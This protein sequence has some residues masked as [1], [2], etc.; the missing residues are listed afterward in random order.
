MKIAFFSTKSY[1]KEFFEAANQTFNHQIDFHETRLSANTTPIANGAD[2]VCVFVNDRVDREV[3]ESL[4]QEGVSAVALR[5]SGFNNVDMSAANELGLRVVRVPEYSP[6]AVAEHAVGL[7]LAL[8][9]RLYR[10]Y[11]RVRDG[12][13][14]LAG[15]LGFDLYGKTVGVIG[16]GK[17]GECICRIL[18]G[19]GC[20]VIASDPH[21]NPQCVKMG[22]EY[23]ENDELFRESAVLMLQCPLVKETYHL[24]DA[25]SISKMPDG[26]MIINTSR[27]GVIDTRAVI[28]GLKS[29]KVGALGIDVYEEEADLFFED[30][31]GSVITDDV[32]ARLLTFPNVLITGHQGFFTTE[33]LEK[34]A[35]VTL[36]NL[37][38]L[39]AGRNCENE[40]LLR[41]D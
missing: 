41:K 32:F 5:C 24:V 7:M 33:A 29:G 14:R 18:L 27:G 13:F 34:I 26:A 36:S 2:A 17:I 10:A 35:D 31:S 39:A 25:D 3:L 9:R 28:D 37:S 21:E 8:N 40:V 30:L 16:T 23:V 22:V 19:F 4:K 1:D 20:R 12:D 38:D 11:N 6:H 15:L